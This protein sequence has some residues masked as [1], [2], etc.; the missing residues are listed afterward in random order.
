VTSKSFTAVSSPLIVSNSIIKG[1]QSGIE[2][3]K[4]GTTVANS[5]VTGD[6]VAIRIGGCNAT[7]ANSTIT[8]TAGQKQEYF[9]ALEIFGAKAGNVVY[10]NTFISSSGAANLVEISV[11][12]PALLYW[13][14]FT[15]T[16]GYYI[17]TK[18]PV[19][20]NTSIRGQQ[21]GN[22]YE[23][24][25][26]GS[27]AI[28]GNS[29]SIGFPSLTAG[30]G[31][32]GYPYGPNSSGGKMA[33]KAYDYAPLFDEQTSPKIGSLVVNATPS[34][35]GTATGTAY[36]F[37]APATKPV[38]ASAKPGYLFAGWGISGNCAIA[39]A[40]AASTTVTVISGTCNAIANF[41]A[42][43]NLIVNATPSSGGAVTGTTYNFIVPAAKPVNA[44]AKANY[45]FLYW[46]TAGN[47]TIANAS[48]AST[49][50]TVNSGTCYATA[51][52]SYAPP[53]PQGCVCGDL[54]VPN[55]L[56]NVTAD[57]NSTGTCFNV[58]ASN[59]TIL[60]NNH[61]ISGP[62]NFF[63]NGIKSIANQTTVKECN[64]SRYGIGV[65]F[66][67]ADGGE[68]SNTHAAGI[69]YGIYLSTSSNNT[70]ANCT[71]NAPGSG[72]GVYF[73]AGSDYNVITNTAG[74]GAFGITHSQ[75]SNNIITNSRATSLGANPGMAITGSAN[76]SFLNITANS[77]SG[78]G[79]YMDTS[80]DN[81]IADSTV[82][83]AAGNGLGIVDCTGNTF[84]NNTL[85]SNGTELTTD[86]A[87]GNNLFYW[88]NF[89]ATTGLYV[90]DTNGSNIYNT[91]I[92]GKQEGNIYANVM[93]GAVQVQ[94]NETSSYGQGLYIG[95]NG[96]G[97]PYG[98]IASQG[99]IAGSAVDYAPL[100]PFYFNNTTAPQIGNLVVTCGAFM[101]WGNATLP[102]D[103][104]SLLNITGTAY[105][106]PVPATMPISV[107]WS[108]PHLTFDY[109]EAGPGCPIA[110]I[111]SPNT[112]I[113]VLE[114]TCYPST[115]FSYWPLDPRAGES[116]PA[117]VQDSGK[118]AEG[119]NA[120]IPTPA[121]FDRAL[122]N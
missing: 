94:G 27:V 74:T 106:F 118:Q 57:L 18:S 80:A 1:M 41:G 46:S 114:G 71:G 109:W 79:I 26:S 56:C 111:L 65:L 66:I 45:T 77:A 60:C 101:T 10:N 89:T 86:A 24:V 81:V 78:H 82:A 59:V 37:I 52:F 35:G 28:T 104:C 40:S 105:N 20:L 87:S 95:V 70:I 121:A 33:G 53:A 117:Q 122:T 11:S 69:A 17:E 44:S 102:P 34:S 47:C 88:N 49:T 38:S 120:E 12:S 99:K 30:T 43:G 76:N 32:L 110:D 85:S 9:S 19:M 58:T 73:A 75:S 13:N 55:Y 97:L 68:I 96:T 92:N 72:Y 119:A 21:E 115:L 8:T 83:S 91:I 39:N 62:N 116:E 61:S 16:N 7:I 84:A 2:I 4:C 100:T 113:T 6:Y 29:P 63:T 107:S 5:Q 103:P 23:N 108:D 98:A 90:N 50:V 48:A 42:A 31:G 112:T 22:I 15:K 51:Y 14:N 54:N 64:I 93:S 25:M 36:N 3:D 67:G